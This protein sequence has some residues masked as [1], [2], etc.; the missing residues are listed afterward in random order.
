MFPQFQAYLCCSSVNLFYFRNLFGSEFL[1]VYD[2]SLFCLYANPAPND[3]G[4]LKLELLVLVQNKDY[5]RVHWGMQ[6][7]KR[8][9]TTKRG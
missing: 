6:K 8:T 4:S 7:T 2:T 3:E 9:K 5:F 1:S